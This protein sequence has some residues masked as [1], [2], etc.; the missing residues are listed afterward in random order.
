[1][2]K[3]HKLVLLVAALATISSTN[4]AASGAVRMQLMHI[5]A[6]RGLTPHD[7]LHRM[8]QRSRLSQV[9]SV[10]ITPGKLN[11]GVPDTEYLAHLSIGTPAQPVQLTLDSGSDLIWTQCLPCV[12][13]FHQALPIFNTSLSSTFTELPCSSAACQDLPATSCRAGGSSKAGDQEPC[14]YGYSYGDGSLTYGRLVADTFAFA[15]GAAVPVM[16][17]GCGLNNTGIFKSN[18]TGIVGFGRGPLSLPSQLKVDNFSYCFTDITGSAPSPVLLGVPPNVFSRDHSAVHT[19]P[20]IQNPARP[21]LYYL[22]LKGITVGSTML[23]IPESRFALTNN[24]TGGTIIDSGTCMTMFPSDVYKLVHDAFIAQARLPV[25]NNA[26]ATTPLCFTSPPGTKPKV[27]RLILHFDG[28]TLDLPRENYMFELQ[29]A[30]VSITCLA[31]NSGGAM[32]IIGNYQQQNM[33]VLYDL[34]N[35]KLSFVPA[36]CD[37]V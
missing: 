21:S 11:N 30:G 8:A 16:A 37:M 31:V 9:A 13:C 14:R 29:D 1:M 20:F 34:A 28:A 7:L 22:Y 17:F 36:Q 6:R 35:N 19:T 27:P 32:T 23:P 25:F 12:S 4:A 26:T 2:I 24:G 33:H 18:E 5:D 15:G 3:M 10:P